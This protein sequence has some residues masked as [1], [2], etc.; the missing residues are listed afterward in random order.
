MTKLLYVQISEDITEKIKEGSLQRGAKLS[1]RK[2][3]EQYEVSRAVI[4]DALKLL[5]EKGLVRTSAGR[6]SFVNIPSGEELMGKFEEAVDNSLITSAV[7]MEA[8]EVIELSYMHLVA[9][10]ATKKDIG[11]L[12]DI[13]AEMRA[14]GDDILAFARL[15]EAFHLALAN[16]T[17]NEA[18]SMFSG[19][20]NTITNRDRLLI[21]KE[22]RDRAMAEHEIL[23]EAV[24]KHDVTMLTEGM[25]KHLTC[26]RRHLVRN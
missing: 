20:L 6:G 16:C 2:L 8:R 11:K 3:A 25:K 14:S 17:H 15:D 18:L 24:E 10:R 19:S 26:V 21:S 7:A 22:I 23:L 4:R 1:E 9:E 12:K 13:M 5:N